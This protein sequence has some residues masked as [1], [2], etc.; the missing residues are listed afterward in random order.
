MDYCT[1]TG[2]LT[3]SGKCKAQFTVPEL[4]DNSLIKYN[5]HIT[6]IMGVY[7]MIIIGQ[8]ILSDLKINLLYSCS[9]DNLQFSDS[10]VVSANSSLFPRATTSNL[11]V[12][13][14]V[15]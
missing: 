7:D 11:S 13:L 14:V 4:H 10:T 9:L 8:D 1:P 3:T 6:P 5:L 12:V 15:V 2:E